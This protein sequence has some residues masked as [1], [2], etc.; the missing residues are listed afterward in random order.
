VGDR[1]AYLRAA[2]ALLDTSEGIRV[3]GRSSVYKTE[4]VN[5]AVSQRDFYNAAVKLETEL[6]PP[7]LLGLCKR[8]ERELGRSPGG[9]RHAP[10]RIDL[11]LLLVP[12]IKARGNPALP[13]PEL[14]HRRF[15]LVPLLELEPDLVTPG[16]R[17]LAEALAHLGCGQ[18]VERVGRLA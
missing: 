8:I 10:R 17:P 11:D 1:L 18:R 12:G 9:P 16:G 4:P 7:A 3:V 15:V 5:G 14:E 6:D 2:V 13:H